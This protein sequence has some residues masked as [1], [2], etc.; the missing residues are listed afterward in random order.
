M[1]SEELFD[2]DSL[3][4]DE[5]YDTTKDYFDYNRDSVNVIYVDEKENA[6]D[7]LET[8]LGFFERKDNLKW[9]WIAMC[10]HHSL[11]SFAI[12]SLEG[13]NY[14]TVLSGGHGDD[15]NVY[16]RI[17]NDKPRKSRIVPFFIKDYR[18]PAY[19]IEWDEVESF[20]EHK[21]KRESEKRKK[22]K[23][24]TFWTAL[25]RI[26]DNYYYMRRY[27]HSKAVIISDDELKRICWLSEI[28]RNNLMH[29]VPKSY[30]IG[31]IDIIETAKIIWGIIRS[32]VFESNLILFID[33]E[34]S[35]KRIRTTL[36]ILKTKLKIE[37]EI[38]H[39]NQIKLNQIQRNNDSK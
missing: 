19:R 36:D 11:Y 14:Q 8:A 27:I 16:V 37:E 22:E 28:V 35:Q 12:S 2:D 7:S 21:F 25:A 9:K 18:T 10:L 4:E 38:I 31:I 39:L 33:F 29:F 17:G 24:I 32:L 34:K 3:F 5:S 6:I 30:A 26:Q 20:P 1:E 13:G 15:K 23:L